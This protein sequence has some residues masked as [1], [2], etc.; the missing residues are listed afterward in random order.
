MLQQLGYA[1][2]LA[3]NGAEALAALEKNSYDLVF[4]D[5]QMPGLDGLETTRRIRDLERRAA[6]P[7]VKVIAM[8]ANAMLGDR[9]KCLA[10]GMDDYLAKPVRPEALQAAFP[11]AA[12]GTPLEGARLSIVLVP[13][14]G[15]CLTHGPVTLDLQ[16]GLRCPVCD[17]PTPTLLQG[18]ELE[19]DE[20]ELH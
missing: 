12:E 3:S 19:L 11:A 2:D 8:T 5:V 14:V 20:L 13:G 15:E 1:A 9:D 10:A 16:R 6:R 4:M 7:A 18:D 17:L